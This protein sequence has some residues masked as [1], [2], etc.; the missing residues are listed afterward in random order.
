MR[1]GVSFSAVLRF[2]SDALLH[3]PRLADGGIDR[4]AVAGLR[5]LISALSALRGPRRQRQGFLHTAAWLGFGGKSPPRP[6]SS[7]D[8][9]FKLYGDIEIKMNACLS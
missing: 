3:G 1:I 5:A 7:D 9:T 2:D 6:I 8:K 4:G